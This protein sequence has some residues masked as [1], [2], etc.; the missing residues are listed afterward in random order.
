MIIARIVAGYLI[1]DTIII[2]HINNFTDFNNIENFQKYN[3]INKEVK[4]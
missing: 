1:K 4:L 2:K 3:I